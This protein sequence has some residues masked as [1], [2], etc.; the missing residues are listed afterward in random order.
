LDPRFVGSNPAYDDG[1]FRAIRIHCTTSFGGEVKPAV[2]CKILHHVKYPYSV[3]G[4]LVGKIYEY[5]SPCFFL[6]LS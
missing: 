4:I 3:K 5:F 1:I 6:L 2:P